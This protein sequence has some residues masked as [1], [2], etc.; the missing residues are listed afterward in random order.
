MGITPD[1]FEVMAADDIQALVR[2]GL[3]VVACVSTTG[4]IVG[5]MVARD[6]CS[7]VPGGVD[8]SDKFKPIAALV[9]TLTADYMAHKRLT[10]GRV[11]YPYMLGVDSRFGG[12]GI[13]TGVTEATLTHARRR[14]YTESF[15]VATNTRSQQLFRCLGFVEKDRVS[16]SDFLFEGKAVFA[17]ITDS[18]IILMELPLGTTEEY[19]SFSKQEE[20]AR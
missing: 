16:Y 2:D 15:L 10:P 20:R 5:V 11:L 12:D 14:G 9:D 7:R 13:G 19:T 3:S 1:E 6:A 8:V 17:S 4:Q 18:A